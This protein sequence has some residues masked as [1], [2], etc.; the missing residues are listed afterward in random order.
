MTALLA[1]FLLGAAQGPSPFEQAAAHVKAGRFAEA[2]PILRDLAARDPSP[3]TD[4]YLGLCLLARFEHE[5]AES[6]LRRAIEARRR[7]HSW[8]HA[9][10]KS[11]LDRGRSGDALELLDR[12]IALRD[13]PEY[14]FAKAAAAVDL[15][16]LALAEEELDRALSSSEPL[17]FLDGA[18]VFDGRAEALFQLGKLLALRGRD[19]ESQGAFADALAFDS[20]HFEARVHLGLSQ[21]RLGHLRDARSALERAV[22][23]RPEHLGALYGLYQTLLLDGDRESAR[24]LAS[25]LGSLGALEGRIQYHLTSADSLERTLEDTA[26]DEEL[27]SAVVRNRLALGEALVAAGREEE[28]LQHLLAARRLEPERSETYRRLA[29]VFRLLDRRADAEMAEGIASELASKGR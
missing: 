10:A 9:L 27:R 14:R 20:S 15:G 8:M 3:A 29:A 5:E 11:L 6:F 25:R 4:Y 19:E 17:R 21:K 24:S 12:A 16:E 18:R 2:E 23:E 28:A 1:I 22:E 7:E 13:R 26:E